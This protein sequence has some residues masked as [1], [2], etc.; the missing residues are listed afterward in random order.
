MQ[1]RIGLVPPKVTVSQPLKYRL[2]A[3][4][5]DRSKSVV[6]ACG[7]EA[8]RLLPGAMADRRSGGWIMQGRLYADPGGGGYSFVNSRDSALAV[9]GPDYGTRGW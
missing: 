9:P 2:E 7:L 3:S 5:A 4:T 6:P 8:K 1:R